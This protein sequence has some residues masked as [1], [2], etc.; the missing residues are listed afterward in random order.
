LLLGGSAVFPVEDIFGALI[1]KTDDHGD[2]IARI[3]CY[4]NRKKLS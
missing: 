1:R 3:S 2:I 4:V